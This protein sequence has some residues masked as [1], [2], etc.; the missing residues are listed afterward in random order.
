[1]NSLWHYSS[2]ASCQMLLV[3]AASPFQT[4][5]DPIPSCTLVLKWS[6]QVWTGAVIDMEL[7]FPIYVEVR[8]SMFGSVE[9]MCITSSQFQVFMEWETAFFFYQIVVTRFCSQGIFG[10][11]SSHCIF[12]RGSPW[13]VQH[14]IKCPYPNQVLKQ[15]LLCFPMYFFVLFLFWGQGVMCLYWVQ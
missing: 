11:E 13:F 4:K 5:Y 9:Q 1:M 12:L 14:Q 15:P 2:C 8:V 7:F 6:Q 3:S 10:L